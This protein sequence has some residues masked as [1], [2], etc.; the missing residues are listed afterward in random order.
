[1][2]P[3]LAI[4]CAAALLGGCTAAPKNIAPVNPDA[5]PEARQLLEFLYSVRGRIRWLA[6]TTSSA[7]RPATT[8][9]SMP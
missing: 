3:I 5:S 4:L 8:A 9:W 2:K 6:S 1:M 7:N